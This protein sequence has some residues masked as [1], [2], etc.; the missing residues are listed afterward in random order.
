MDDLALTPGE[1]AW[2]AKILRDAKMFGHDAAIESFTLL[3]GASA[4]E[5]EKRLLILLG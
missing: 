4:A 2:R 1:D 5:C 3:D